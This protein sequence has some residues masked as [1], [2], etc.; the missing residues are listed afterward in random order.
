MEYTTEYMKTDFQTFFSK[1]NG[2]LLKFNLLIHG[3]KLVTVYDTPKTTSNSI[4]FNFG[5]QT[6]KSLKF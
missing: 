6:R 1:T 4:L 2:V 5:D 3:H